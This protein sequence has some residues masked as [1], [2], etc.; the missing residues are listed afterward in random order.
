MYITIA[1]YLSRSMVHGTF[2]CVVGK[3]LN[4]SKLSTEVKLTKKEK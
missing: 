1:D 2:V 3:K 4:N